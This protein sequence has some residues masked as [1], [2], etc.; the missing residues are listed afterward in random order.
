MAKKSVTFHDLSD[1]APRPKICK[2]CGQFINPPRTKSAP[3]EKS[4]TDRFL[5]KGQPLNDIQKLHWEFVSS[6]VSLKDAYYNLRERSDLKDPDLYESLWDSVGYFVY[7]VE[8]Q[9]SEEIAIDRMLHC[10]LESRVIRPNTV[11]CL[12]LNDSDYL[13]FWRKD[14]NHVGI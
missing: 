14:T 8:R 9:G 2:C 12:I 11:G 13:F 4:R 1:D 7:T 3:S 5:A 6:D 10:N